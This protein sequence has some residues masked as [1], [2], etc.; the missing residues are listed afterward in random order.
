MQ[1][2]SARRREGVDTALGNNN[3]AAA[4][5]ALMQADSAALPLI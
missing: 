4:V 2:Y 1:V 5:L 3:V